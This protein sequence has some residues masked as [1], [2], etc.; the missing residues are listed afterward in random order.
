M[1]V[2]KITNYLVFCAAADTKPTGMATDALTYV[3]DTGDIYR[4]NGTSWGL[5]NDGPAGTTT[6]TNKTINATNNTITDTSTALGDILKSDG[7]KFAR[8]ARGTNNQ[9][10]ASTSTTIAWTSLNSENTGKATGSGTGSATVFNVAH[11]LGS[12]P[13][14]AMINCSSHTITFTYTTDSTNIVVTFS[15]APASGTNNVIFYWR[16]VA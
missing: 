13:S 1:T 2:K 5:F 7:T 14:N 6:L 8:M 16:A 11:G 12:V 9:V 15:S 4:Y 10:L 3:T